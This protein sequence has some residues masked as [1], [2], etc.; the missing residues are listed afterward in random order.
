MLLVNLSAAIEFLPPTKAMV[1]HLSV[2]ISIYNAQTFKS[3]DVEGLFLVYGYIFG[4]F[5]VRF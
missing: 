4:I 2:S 5:R 3:F 1:T